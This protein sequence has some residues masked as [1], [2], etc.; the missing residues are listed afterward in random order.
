MAPARWAAVTV[1]KL[2]VCDLS[3]S[4]RLPSGVAEVMV[5]EEYVANR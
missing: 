2:S 4:S 3:I 1:K 5:G